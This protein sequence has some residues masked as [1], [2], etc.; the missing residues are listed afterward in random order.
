MPFGDMVCERSGGRGFGIP[1]RPANGP[2]GDG[3][4]V[5]LDGVGVTRDGAWDMLLVALVGAGVDMRKLG[6]I[7]CS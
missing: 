3:A 1:L 6:F 4:D 5:D 7:C 2:V